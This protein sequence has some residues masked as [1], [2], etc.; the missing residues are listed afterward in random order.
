MSLPLS[1][2]TVS[3]IPVRAELPPLSTRTSTEHVQFIARSPQNAKHVTHLRV[4]Q[5]IKQQYL[6]Q[7]IEERQWHTYTITN[8]ATAEC[9]K[10]ASGP[11]QHSSSKDGTTK[12][13]LAA[14]SIV[15]MMAFIQMNECDKRSILPARTKHDHID[16]A[17]HRLESRDLSSNA[18]IDNS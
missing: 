16:V 2:S 7:A 4:L 15:P 3:K 11:K 6:E 10:M 5:S 17:L 13:C 18:W 8:R 1:H 9:H 14:Q 12:T